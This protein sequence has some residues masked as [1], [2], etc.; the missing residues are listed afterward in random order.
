MEGIKQEK[1]I[2]EGLKESTS[3]QDIMDHFK[4]CGPINNI[5]INKSHNSTSA[6]ISFKDQSSLFKA[7][8]KNETQIND[9]II[10]LYIKSSQNN[11]KNMNINNHNYNTRFSKKENKIIN[12]DDN[13]DEENLQLND[14]L[15]SSQI[16]KNESSLDNQSYEENESNIIEN[17]E[18][19][20]KIDKKIKKD[21]NNDIRYKEK[22]NN[23]NLDI[24]DIEYNESENED[25]IS[26]NEG[27]NN[28]MKEYKQYCKGIRKAIHKQVDG[29]INV[30]D[31]LNKA[32]NY[33]LNNN[34]QEA[35]EVLETIISVSPNLQEPYLILSQ[36]YEDEKNDEKSLFFLMLAAQ[37]SRGDKDIWI[38]CC[39]YNKKLRNY[40]QA[41][42]CI[43]RA[44][45]LDK[46]NLY[47]LYERGAL[48][49]ELGDIFKAIKIYIVL[50]KLYP[51]Y[52]ILLHILMLYERTKNYEKA[53]NLFE[54]F[55][56]KLQSKNK[57][58]AIVFL[59]SFYIKHK[60]YY[61]GY[62]FYIN[63]ISISKDP[64]IIEMIA[65]NSLFKLKK[66]FCFLYLSINKN[67]EID[68]Q[69]NIDDIVK[70][71]IDEFNF[72]I[73]SENEA[74][75]GDNC[76]KDNL[77][78]LFNILDELNK[79]DIFEKIYYD[80]EKK[81]IKEIKISSYKNIISEVKFLLGN[82][83]FKNKIYNKSILLYE[84]SL[85]Y[86]S[87]SSNND[88]IKNL[89]LIKLS[90]SYQ[91]VGN[92]KKAID[93]LN[94]SNNNK[95]NENL[96]N[97]NNIKKINSITNNKNSNINININVNKNININKNKN[98]N[99]IDKK[100]KINIDN[101]NINEDNNSIVSSFEEKINEEEFNDYEDFIQKQINENNDNDNENYINNNNKEDEEE[102]LDDHDHD[103]DNYN[104]IEEEDDNI[105]RKN[106]NNINKE[107]YNLL[108]EEL[109]NKNNILN[110]NYIF[111]NEKSEDVFPSKIMENFL[112]RKRRYYSS[113]LHKY[114][115]TSLF[116]EN[117]DKDKEKDKNKDKEYNHN[118][119]RNYD[120]SFDNYLH[121]KMR[122]LNNN[123]RNSNN[124]TTLNNIS[125]DG[126]NLNDL[127]EDYE[128][129]NIEN[130][131][132]IDLYLKLQESLVLLNNNE[133]DKFL[134]V[135]YE[136]LKTILTQE[137]Q[138]EN[139]LKDLFRYLLEKSSIKNYFLKKSNIF[140]KS[141]FDENLG[142]NIT[143]SN[144]SYNNN[145]INL[146]EE[147][148]NNNEGEHPLDNERIL[149]DNLFV[150]K[151][152]SKI[153]LTKK[154]VVYTKNFIEKELNSLDLLS[155]YISKDNLR[156]IISQFIIHSYNKGFNE[157]AF[158][159][160]ILILNS[161]KIIN[162]NNYFCYDAVIYSIM[163]CFKK[164]LY[165]TSLE[166]LKNSIIKY[167]LQ[168]LPFFWKQLWN[169][170]TNISSPIA[171][172]YMYKLAI[173]KNLSNNPLLKLIISLCYYKTN[174]FEFCISNLKDLIGQYNNNAY[175][176]F[177]LSLSYLHYAQNKR[178]T[179]KHEKYIYMKKYF[180]LY[181][182]KRNYECP[183]EV[184][185]NE[186][187]LYQYLGIYNEAWNKYQEVCDKI[188]NVN[189]I[190]KETKIKIK[191]STIYN[192]H[193]I[194]LKGGNEQKAQEIL[195]NNLII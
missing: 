42:Y 132:N 187:R 184:I 161:Y 195:Y 166:L 90:E 35:K 179:N 107:E 106:K 148:E 57:I 39:N 36:I 169:I 191:S 85:L 47:I 129:L 123:R 16:I 11:N 103:N 88:K 143:M 186:G 64:N 127:K 23:D 177:L 24:S 86:F 168:L 163:I 120:Y 119:L 21:K 12:I 95:T 2:I 125:L 141:L 158:N 83:Y 82:Y 18:K 9:S 133:I 53:M 63:K 3:I 37:S 22:L 4:D 28:F 114:D 78:I 139:Y 73:D 46:N 134:D 172:S 102:N 136:P 26:D 19:K 142:N 13:D 32:N 171:R 87:P 164:K 173:N 167:D 162:K 98:D 193:L 60:Q 153:F 49:E 61:K 140:D 138:I 115:P 97:I 183:I 33:Y 94:K 178:T 30:Q 144:I 59:Y 182:I 137:L 130:K 194:L 40:R 25:N 44:L 93:I 65:N 38:K 41:E 109:N 147:D 54:E 70:Q 67:N 159:I 181:K 170:C 52:D 135:T 48:N 160:I 190:N 75:Y 6:E 56:D 116:N 175:L 31:L 92:S 66:L 189:Y 55:Y 27:Y 128:K 58:E 99:I 74:K 10:N 96:N 62:L 145:N 150:R 180:S 121:R 7:L 176:Y 80:L 131:K 68:G 77:H 118:N 112:S 192:M 72:L 69:L 71:I 91:Q 155:K 111:S 146:I 43:T 117:K 15:S 81:L 76:I 185:Y 5:Y 8:N 108:S 165:K 45:K 122:N 50:L 154:K 105:N 101:N 89:I 20:I 17:E 51:N 151:S 157:E 29:E 156:K 100:N 110:M 84:N 174:Y 14:S 79:I 152:T 126:L 34:Y 1:L 149:T 104:E 113:F 124:N 188:D